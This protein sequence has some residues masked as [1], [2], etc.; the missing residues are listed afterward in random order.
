MKK[1]EMNQ[2]EILNGSVSCSTGLAGLAGAFGIL[3]AIFPPVGIPLAVAAAVTGIA[4]TECPNSS[5]PTRPNPGG[6]SRGP[7]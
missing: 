3:A 5:T 2:M 4:A 1:L 6:G 7:R